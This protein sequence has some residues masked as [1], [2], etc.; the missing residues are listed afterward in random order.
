MPRSGPRP[1]Q[2]AVFLDLDGTLLEIVEQPH[3]VRVPDW[4]GSLLASTADRLD[5]ALALLSGR[6]IAEL[7][8]LLGTTDL[9]AAGIHG[10]ERRGH[11]R[12]VKRQDAAPVPDDVRRRLAVFSRNNAGILIEDKKHSIAVHFRQAPDKAD[13]VSD[14]MTS[15]LSEIDDSFM[16]QSGKMVLELRPR[17]TS[18]GS[19]LI[20]FMHERPFTGRVPVFIGDDVTDEDGFAVVNSLH[21]YSV[22]VG[23]NGKETHARYSLPDVNAVHDWLE[24]LDCEL[25]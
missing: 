22:R 20:D 15:I 8:S 13:S 24:S 5:G 17:G 23:S 9:P 4:L 18:K 14:E 16:L 11:D 21:G 2:L 25:F 12:I 10:L 6:P 19:A 7:D 3:L 1:R